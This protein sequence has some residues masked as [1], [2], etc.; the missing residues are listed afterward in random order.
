M[1]IE[2][3]RIFR[4]RCFLAFPDMILATRRQPGQP[5]SRLSS[6]LPHKPRPESNRVGGQPGEFRH[7]G[8][9]A[10]TGQLLKFEIAPAVAC[11]PCVISFSLN[12][13]ARLASAPGWHQGCARL[14]VMPVCG[15]VPGY[16]EHLVD[17]RGH[18]VVCCARLEESDAQR[19]PVG[20]SAR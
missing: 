4:I 16:A 2:V 19:C 13:H 9:G 6:C 8:S 5:L 7:H 11:W 15:P 3:S 12:V 14:L 10:S 18:P 20:L 17:I 1:E